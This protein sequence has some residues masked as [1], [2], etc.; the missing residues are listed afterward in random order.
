MPYKGK[1]AASANDE[2]LAAIRS[3]L[4]VKPNNTTQLKKDVS[5]KPKI[6]KDVIDKPKAG[7]DISEESKIGRNVPDKSKTNKD[8]LKVSSSARP[9]SFDDR[10][11]RLKE[12][13][14]EQPKDFTKLPQKDNNEQMTS[15]EKL[16]EKKSS[17]KR[18]TANLERRR[19]SDGD[20]DEGDFSSFL[21]EHMGRKKNNTQEKKN[22][23][24]TTDE[25]EQP[26]MMNDDQLAE[27]FLNDTG[28]QKK[29]NKYDHYTDDLKFAEEKEAVEN[30]FFD[31]RNNNTNKKIEKMEPIAGKKLSKYRSIVIEG[32]LPDQLSEFQVHLQCG[33]EPYPESDIALMFTVSFR[34]PHIS[35][36]AFVKGKTIQH[37][38]YTPFFPVIT[39]GEFY[40]IISKSSEKW[41][42]YLNGYYV[43]EFPHVIA[44]LNRVNYINVYGELKVKTIDKHM[45]DI[46]TDTM[47]KVACSIS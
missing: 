44:D 35:R 7:K 20:E 14:S 24:F 47:Q 45:V 38:T 29:T 5:D 46:S 17:T 13:K 43:F 9:K 31:T 6:G 39:P 15:K 11:N 30:I 40:I 36:N 37:T 16:G 42:I 1:G 34:P 19:M 22:P 33:K 26:Q 8:E 4:E 10:S 23:L 41:K 3:R 21:A 25:G 2:R 12:M 28:K 18:I 32:T 27:N